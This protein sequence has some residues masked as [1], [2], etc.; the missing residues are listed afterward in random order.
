MQNGLIRSLQTLGLHVVLFIPA[1]LFAQQ[2]VLSAGG[3]V[4]SAS[5]S[6]N[7]SIGQVLYGSQYTD[8]FS[9]IQGV[10]QPYD[11]RVVSGV[12]QLNGK[13]IACSVFPNPAL[14]VLTI[15]IDPFT[16]GHFHYRLFDVSGRQLLSGPVNGPETPVPV[17]TLA[18]AAYLLEVLQ[19]DQPV[20][21]FKIIKH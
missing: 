9:L 4:R 13:P 15:R 20:S 8:G 3:D 7:F 21:K 6:T 12:T 16:N 5:G 17:G 14:E 10:Q 1:G 2:A 18:S 19:G 11:V